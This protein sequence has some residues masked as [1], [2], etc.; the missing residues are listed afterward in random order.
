[1]KRFFE[2]VDKTGGGD[3][4]WLWTAAKCDK[5]YGQFRES[6]VD[7]G[8]TT[9]GRQVSAHRFS[10]ALSHGPIPKGMYVCHHCDTPSCVN[11]AH[12]FLGTPA[13]NSADRNN[14]NRHAHGERHG[15]AKLTDDDV[16]E[17]RDLL[18][19]SRYA[20]WEI[21]VFY[22]VSRP[23]ISGINAEKAWTHVA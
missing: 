9:R 20:H 18:V 21:G 12:L 17:I 8:R 14:K 19:A 13:D 10:Y 11:P 22:G 3:S 15:N 4:C 1:M 5:G 23:I 6:G 2:K 16:R 7:N